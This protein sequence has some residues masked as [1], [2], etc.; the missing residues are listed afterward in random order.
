MEQKKKFMQIIDC[1]LS[2]SHQLTVDELRTVDNTTEM[3]ILALVS[4]FFELWI[5]IKS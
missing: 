5:S 1:L 2:R 3:E 4:R